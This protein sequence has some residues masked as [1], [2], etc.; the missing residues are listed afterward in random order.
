VWA[1][2]PPAH[3]VLPPPSRTSQ[4]EQP[5]LQQ[6]IQRYNTR[7]CAEVLSSYSGR[8]KLRQARRPFAATLFPPHNANR[9]CSFVKCSNKPSAY[10]STPVHAVQLPRVQTWRQETLPVLRPRLSANDARLN[11]GR[12]QGVAGAA[13]QRNA[14][15]TADV[16]GGSA[17]SWHAAKHAVAAGSR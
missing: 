4:H 7:A 14:A 3:P 6:A 2:C 11:S 5:K 17:R 15:G 9:P 12:W 1:E 16:A 13:A 8:N 10:A